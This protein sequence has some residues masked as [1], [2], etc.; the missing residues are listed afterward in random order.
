MDF[1]EAK[2]AAAREI[3][4][5]LG[6]PPMLF[7]IP[8]DNTYTEDPHDPGGPTNFGII[9]SEFAAWKGERLDAANTERLKGD[10]KRID[11][12][13]VRDI[14]FANYWQAAGC[15]EL[16]PALAL[17]HF[18][19]AVNHGVGTAI[20]FLQQAV[21]AGVDGEIGPETRA[22]VQRVPVAEALATYAELR[23]RRYRS[24]K[25]FWRFGRGWLR[26]VDVTLT[27]AREWTDACLNTQ[28]Q[29][30]GETNMTD[31]SNETTTKWWGHSLTI[32]GT[33]VS[34]L[35]VVVPAVGPA[36]GVDI[37][38][39]LV[40]NAGDDVV[41]AVQ[42]VAALVGTL[43]TIYGRIRATQPITRRTLNLKI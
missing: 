28:P 17:M 39:D 8:G 33:I 25:H 7:G 32:W 9:L 10:L 27:R 24:L 5:A 40:Q 41:S 36:V 18:D 13:T 35:A 11:A 16:P 6:V 14:Y 34:A 42:G 31:T 30:Q 26:R 20:R 38:G 43:M 29:Q 23:R 2:N 3:A 15:A 4:L 12:Q 19:A 1:I 22:A 37:S 21:G